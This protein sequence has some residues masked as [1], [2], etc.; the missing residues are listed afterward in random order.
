MSPPP[1]V[2]LGSNNTATKSSEDTY[3]IK[4]SV[5]YADGKPVRGIK[6]QVM[7][8]DQEAFQD[9]NDDVIAIVPINDSDGTFEVVFD[10]KAFKEGWLEGRPDVYLMVRNG[11]YYFL[12][13]IY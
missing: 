12:T 2:T 9:H 8:S 7:D 5:K 11:T 10:P 13:K 1:E 3:T 4:G 6:I